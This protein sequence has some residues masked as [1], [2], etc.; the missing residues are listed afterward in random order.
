MI[1][2]A[3]VTC[4]RLHLFRQCIASFGSRAFASEV[5]VIDDNSSESDR[6][7]MRELVPEAQLL[8]K[9]PAQK[10]H[11]HSLNFLLKHVR[12]RFLMI[13]EDDFVFLPG[14]NAKM[15]V[16]QMLAILDAQPNA[17]QVLFNINYSETLQGAIIGPG[18]RKTTPVGGYE[19][20]VHEHD[21]AGRSKHPGPNCAY[22]PHFSLRPGLW[23]LERIR[24]YLAP[25]HRLVFDPY[26]DHFEMAFAKTYTSK[27]MVTCF[28]PVVAMKHIGKLTSDHSG[29]IKNAYALNDEP[30]FVKRDAV[31][32]QRWV[33][34]NLAKRPDRRQAFEER[35]RSA[36]VRVIDRVEA[37]D[38]STHVLA[39]DEC[40]L[41]RGCD[42][43]HR[44]GIVGC[45]LTH[46]R[47]W[48]D[49]ARGDNQY[50][51]VFEDDYSPPAGL[52]TL[53]ERVKDALEQMRDDDADILILAHHAVKTKPLPQGLVSTSSESLAS[54][55]GGTGAYI[56]SQRGAEK[57]VHFIRTRGFVHAVDT[58]LQKSIDSGVRV[59]YLRGDMC[60]STPGIANNAPDVDSNIQ[61]TYSP[62]RFY[63]TS[64]KN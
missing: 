61:H 12:T 43:S 15:Y 35:M 56:L 45:A 24:I 9:T 7:A 57:L 60:G 32:K 53:D 34:I 59:S 22:W 41:F 40:F 64:V 33:Y 46:Y 2:L 55:Y 23:D 13:V 54:S 36:T 1:T 16:E 31:D 52:G 19:Y 20:V 48:V 27:G 6:D 3:F 5:W 58:M 49:F 10:G 51:V 42:Y 29:A 37:V 17:G 18:I 28:L 14:H 47:L 39:P 8:F 4:K 38:G 25:D 63:Y 11:A 50:L 44:Q 62:V 30:Q 21:P 26:E